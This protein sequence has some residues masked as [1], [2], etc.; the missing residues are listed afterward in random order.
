[1]E[2][3]IRNRLAANQELIAKLA[4]QMTPEGLIPAIYSHKAADDVHL[5]DGSYP[6]II[7]SVNRFSDPV[8]DIGGLLT[9]DVL[10]SHATTEP[11]ALAR[12]VKETLNNV[13]FA[14]QADDIFLLKW[15]TTEEFTEPASERL[16]QVDGVTLTFEM[17]AFPNQITQEP[18]PIAALQAWTAR[19]G[20]VVIG[21]SDFGE[22]FIPTH[23]K[24]AFYFSGLEENYVRQTHSTIWLDGLIRCH[25]F[26]PDVQSRRK[27]LTFFRQEIIFCTHIF[28]ADGSPMRLE[29]CR[30]NFTDSELQGQM[31]LTFR[32]GLWRRERDAPTLES[33]VIRFDKNL[34]WQEEE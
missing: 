34:R 6:Q 9:V 15:S 22:S 23:L 33:K 28:L 27:W 5:Q 1:M 20:V 16:P 32:F 24:P 18:D 3:L 25:V 8:H 2:T 14:P 13:F 11:L 4:A 30:I 17:R 10:C 19:L 21:H 29:G 31:L 12:L 26:A 7:F